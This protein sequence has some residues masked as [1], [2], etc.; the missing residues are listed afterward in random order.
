MTLEEMFDTVEAISPDKNGCKI[1]PRGKRDGYANAW[2]KDCGDTL[3][4]REIL[5]KKL[6]YRLPSHLYACH[7]CD[8]RAC[9]NPEHLWA[10]TLQ[11]NIADM[12]KKGRAGMK[13]RKGKQHPTSG[14]QL[15]GEAHSK[16]KLT[17]TSVKEIIIRLQKG[18]N[19]NDISKSYGISSSTV[20]D[21][22]R[23]WTWKHITRS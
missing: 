14:Y 18:E 7:T 19:C 4:T 6:G 16:S 10:G 21:I 15:R 22:K 20:Y 17:E 8:I 13:G 12:T 5:S 3:V 11:E 1:W 23:N 2:I 9:V